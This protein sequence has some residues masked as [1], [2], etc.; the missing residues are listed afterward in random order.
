MRTSEFDEK[1]SQIKTIVDYIK[2]KDYGT[3]IVFM[4]LQP[5]TKYNL[6]DELEF[7]WFKTNIIAKVKKQ[8]IQYGIILKS[9]KYIGYYILKP[10][11]ISSYTYRTYIKKPLKAFEKAKVILE[12][13]NKKGLNEKENNE[14]SLTVELNKELIHKN[15]QILND[16]KYNKLNEEKII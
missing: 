2:G 15:Q 11:Q 10:N 4:E 8:L 6:S 13:V 7:Y 3:T 12:N 1:R 5:F 9:V 14:L 16:V